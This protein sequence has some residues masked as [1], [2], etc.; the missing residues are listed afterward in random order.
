MMPHD[1]CYCNPC[2]VYLGVGAYHDSKTSRRYSANSTTNKTL[3]IISYTW[4]TRIITRASRAKEWSD[5]DT[6]KFK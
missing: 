3:E 6:A 5:L 1:S 2:D 4:Y